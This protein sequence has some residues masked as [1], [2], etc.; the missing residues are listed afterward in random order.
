M[1]QSDHRTTRGL[2]GAGAA[3]HVVKDIQRHVFPTS[4]VVDYPN[5]QREHQPMRAVK[6]GLQRLW[7][8][9]GNGSDEPSPVRLEDSRW[10]IRI[11]EVAEHPPR[12]DI[13]IRIRPARRIHR[14]RIDA[15]RMPRDPCHQGPKRL[16]HHRLRDMGIE[17]REPRIGE[18]AKPVLTREC[19]EQDPLVPRVAPQAPRELEPVHLRHRQIGQHGVRNAPSEL[20]ESIQPVGSGHD[21]GTLR[22]QEVPHRVERIDVVIQHQNGARAQQEPRVHI[23]TAGMSLLAGSATADKRNDVA[24]GDIVV[25]K[26]HPDAVSW[27]DG[28]LG[29][30]VQYGPADLAR[31]PGRHRPTPTGWTCG[32]EAAGGTAQR[33]TEVRE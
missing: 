7:I 27:R 1:I 30:G 13:R 17:P 9:R 32:R 5:G 22:F 14:R 15:G 31:R 12:A 21:I 16:R 6:Q 24:G 11:E 25:S 33:P 29:R 26:S 20:C 23:T 8:S 19:D 18:I 2:V 3:P 4:P 28:P 10:R